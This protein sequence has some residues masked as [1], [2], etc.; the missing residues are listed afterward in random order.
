MGY[1]DISCGTMLAHLQTT[2]SIVTGA[3]D[4]EENWK[5]WTDPWNPDWP[6]EDLW[7]RIRTT[8]TFAAANHDPITDA[9][10]ISLTLAVFEKATMYHDQTVA[11]R[12]RDNTG[13]TLAMFQEHFT[14]ADTEH[15]RNSTAHQTAGYHGAHAAINT[16]PSTPE[17][18]L[19]PNNKYRIIILF[20]CHSHGYTQVPKHT[21]K[22]CTDKKE[23]HQDEA[24]GDN[25]MDGCPNMYVPR[26]RTQPQSR[27]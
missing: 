26:S 7:I 19:S 1:A 10:A 21:S 6:Q 20:Y 4:L 16:T 2:Y 15:S 17:D 27:S 22:T 13:A 25:R 14:R 3:E 5:K 8:Q 18:L 9:V 12:N 11:W 23:N 24:T